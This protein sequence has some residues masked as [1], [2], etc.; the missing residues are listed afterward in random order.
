M[1]Q[2]NIINKNHHGGRKKHSTTTALTQ[3]NN[4]L[5]YNYENNKISAVLA[6][7]LSVA[8]ETIDHCI[9]LKKLEHYG[10]RGDSLMF[11][12]SYLKNRK[13]FVEIDTFP[14]NLVDA[15]DCS[16]SQGSKFSE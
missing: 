2:N 15:L 6:T 14:S 8:F 10:I 1:E 5:L 16:C 12:T 3:I 7:D 9:L 13:Q 11:F 4:I